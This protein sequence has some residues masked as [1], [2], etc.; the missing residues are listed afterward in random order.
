[1]D[2][3]AVVS[4]REEGET[5]AAPALRRELA[6]EAFEIL[7]PALAPRR[8]FG[9]AVVGRALGVAPQPVHARTLDRDLAIVGHQPGRR[10]RISEQP[11]RAGSRGARP[12]RIG[13]PLET[14]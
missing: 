12:R 14:V 6:C 9:E 13:G 3:V 1:D 11:A 2:G 4:Q 7:V 5:I 8:A 10:L